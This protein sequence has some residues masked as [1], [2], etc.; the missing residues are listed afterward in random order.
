MI[1]PAMTHEPLTDGRLRV[2]I[3]RIRPSVDSGRFPLKRVV[4]DV[5]RVGADVFTDGHDALA[6]RL[7]HQLPGQADWIETDMEPLGNDEW[8]ADLEAGSVGLH[9][10]VVTAWID[11]FATWRRDLV[12]RVEAGQQTQ[13]DL[14]IGA[15]LVDDAAARAPGDARSRLLEIADALR[16][17]AG[18]AGVGLAL[19]DELRALMATCP[20]RRFETRSASHELVVDRRDARFAAWYELF[21]RSTSPVPGRHGT[22]LDV[23]ERLPYIADLG[24][25]VLY[26]P[27]VHPVGRTFRKG[28]NNALTAGPGDPGVPWA[29]GS[30][31]GGHMDV[32]PELGTLA[33]LRTLVS[34]AGGHGIRLALDLAL[35][36]S[37]DHP[38]LRE[39]PD[40]FRARPDG[41]I[42]YAENPPK[43]YQDIY[44]FDFESEDWRAMWAWFRDVVR[45][46]VTQGVRVFRVDN[47]HTKPFPF[48]EWLIRDIKSTD[49]DV[50]FLA[51]A[52]TRPKVMYRLAK[53]G[54]SQG[55]TYFTWRNTA[56][57]LRTYFEEISR[58]PVSDFF[59][60]SIWPNTPDILHEYLQL[61]GR[62]AFATRAVLAAMLAAHYGIYGP[63]YELAEATPREPGSEEYLDSEKYQVRD[64]SLDRPDSIAPLIRRLNQIRAAH[65]ALQSNDRLVFHAVDGADLLAWS[66]RTAD[67]SDIVLTV[68]N[69][70]PQRPRSGVLHLP[71]ELFGIDA[72]R[73]FEVHDLLNDRTALWHGEAQEIALDPSET[74][75]HVYHIRPALRAEQ[76]FEQYQ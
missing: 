20:D 18:G 73:P 19:D 75:A 9:R 36:A 59:R 44:P 5:V 55:Y 11:R 40:W 72:Q 21:P 70:D 31:E 42:Q 51:E 14:Q 13:V 12:R 8:G 22:L 41:T 61:G 56:E 4:G 25:D 34:A 62:P 24:F 6:V 38:L 65:P 15:Q 45:F 47:P 23:I 43:R 26:L 46:W 35:Q 48:W 64:W 39:H 76:R 17:D 68:V 49:P 2:V 53:L 60:P 63:A 69:L 66:K 3:E 52:F 50:T 74:P 1:E 10:Y 29:I 30:D 27:P 58:P 67:A 32:H 28:P 7:G 57:E 33:D 16:A 71:L 37:A 54:F